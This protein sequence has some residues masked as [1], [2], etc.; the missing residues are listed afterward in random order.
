MDR[1]GDLLAETQTTCY[2]RVLLPNHAHFLFRTGQVPLATLM[3]RPLTGYVLSFNRRHKHPCQSSLTGQAWSTSSKRLPQLNRST[4]IR[5][6]D[7][8]QNSQDS[9]AK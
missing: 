8:L 3:M 2:G 7:Y 5:Y 4:I 1:L 9:I 6:P